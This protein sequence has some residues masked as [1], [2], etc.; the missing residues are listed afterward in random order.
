MIKFLDDLIGELS[1]IDP[2]KWER[3]DGAAWRMRLDNG[4]TITVVNVA[5]HD[6]LEFFLGDTQIPL[7][8]EQQMKLFRICHGHRTQQQEAMILTALSQIRQIK[9][10]TVSPV[11]TTAAAPRLLAM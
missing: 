7:S 2:E 1:G 11:A 10:K 9:Q 3:H 4:G 5:Q 8:R 6:K